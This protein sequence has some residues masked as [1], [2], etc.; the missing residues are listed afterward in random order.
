MRVPRDEELIKM[1]GPGGSI[2]V[3]VSAS[4]DGKYKIAWSALAMPESGSGK[5]A[6]I[7]EEQ[8]EYWGEMSVIDHGRIANNG[9]FIVSCILDMNEGVR[10]IV[11]MDAQQNVI[12][13]AVFSS[14]GGNPGISANGEYACWGQENEIIFY[15]IYKKNI[16]WKRPSEIGGTAFEYDFDTNS[17]IITTYDDVYGAM[18]YAFDGK[19]LDGEKL[20]QHRLQSGHYDTIHQEIER[21]KQ[22]TDDDEKQK[23]GRK[24]FGIISEKWNLE[25]YENQRPNFARLLGEM[26]EAMNMPEKAISSYRQALQLN[27]KIG[28]KRRLTQ[29]EKENGE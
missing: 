8:I 17:K 5:F 12:L 10:G 29:L 24:L 14:Y 4:P 3:N 6:L 2:L 19:F 16:I 21:I 1:E 26:F 11:I 18:D 28:V 22:S 25:S 23:I 13:K 9:T 15:D 27:P 7:Y 20:Y